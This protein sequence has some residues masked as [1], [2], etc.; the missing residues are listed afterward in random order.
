MKNFEGD[1]QFAVMADRKLAYIGWSEKVS[2]KRG[3]DIYAKFS[4]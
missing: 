1:K 2:L 3:Y 4:M